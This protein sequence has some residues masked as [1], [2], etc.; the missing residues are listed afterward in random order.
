MDLMVQKYR[1]GKERYIK[2]I[3][4][5]EWQKIMA[6]LAATNCLH[7]IYTGIILK[8]S[9]FATELWYYNKKSFLSL[10]FEGL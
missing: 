4:I 6:K 9:E 1:F 7:I 3:N 8:C 5:C 10:F 2:Q